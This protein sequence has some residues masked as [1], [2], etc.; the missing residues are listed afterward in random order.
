MQS[1]V[2]RDRLKRLARLSEG[3]VRREEGLQL[4]EGRRLVD[5]ALAAG[6]VTELFVSD[7]EAERRYR[8]RAGALPLHLIP[9]QDM[10]RLADV[11]TP[12]EVVAVG[13]LPTFL[14]LG[15][16]LEARDRLLLL[17]RIQD[18]GNAGTLART[19][20]AL[21][22]GGV[23]VLEGTAD[24]T[25]PK[26]LRASAGA[27][28]RVDLARAPDGG[29]VLAALRSEKEPRALVLPVVRGGSDVRDALAPTRFILVAGNEGA[30][31]SFRVDHP[32]ALPVTIPMAGGVESL[33]VG[34]A[35]AA[36]LGRWI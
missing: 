20:A 36:I 13:S 23:I 9:V 35:C 8:D 3:K 12:Q 28:F 29:A 11:K 7:E 10:R 21:G 24:L 22:L 30:G 6:R 26:V 19:A 1:G 5:E 18:P 16:I 4:I 2:G 27:L 17:D 14:P 33:N 15:A 25:A 31:S 34:A 32:A